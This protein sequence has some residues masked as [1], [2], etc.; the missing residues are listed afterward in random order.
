MVSRLIQFVDTNINK[1]LN[2]IYN[3]DYFY[4]TKCPPCFFYKE[5]IPYSNIVYQYNS[6]PNSSFSCISALFF[7]AII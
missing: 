2:K 7:C 3:Y 4:K 1:I 6:K 5:G